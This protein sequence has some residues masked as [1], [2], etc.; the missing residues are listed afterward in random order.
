MYTESGS[1]EM[2]CDA[3]LAVQ[4]THVLGGSDVALG[5]ILSQSPGAENL[6]ELV[7]GVLL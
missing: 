2:G 5:W 7:L 6:S 1:S 4:H 3:I